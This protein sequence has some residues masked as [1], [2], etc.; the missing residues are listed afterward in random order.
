MTK[1]TEDISTDWQTRSELQEQLIKD[2]LDYIKEQ[3]PFTYAAAPR[4][5]KLQDRAAALG[6]VPGVK[7]A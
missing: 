5:I 6:V 4:C 3:L 7:N 1:Q 2:L